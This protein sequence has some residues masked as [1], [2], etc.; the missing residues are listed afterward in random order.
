MSFVKLDHKMLTW[1]W[2]DNPNMVA[3]WIEILLQANQFDREWHGEQY[4]RGTFPTSLQKLAD[5]TGLSVRTVRTCLEKLKKS[6]EVTCKVT[7]HGMKISVVKW[8]FY[9]GH[10]KES[11]K[12]TDTQVTSNRQASDKQVTTLIES[13]ESKKVRN[14]YNN[15]HLPVYDPSKNPVMDE[16]EAQE[17]LT[18][19]GKA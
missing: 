1:G 10:D 19:M 5:G 18:L 12:Q 3:L 15:D 4:E 13:K 11:D 2:K 14:I 9:Q 17:L 7:N 6:Q 16:D 8:A